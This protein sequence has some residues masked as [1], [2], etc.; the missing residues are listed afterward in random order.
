[1]EETTNTPETLLSLREKKDGGITLKF[2]VMTG[3]SLWNSYPQIE[4]WIQWGD[5]LSYDGA[6]IGDHYMHDK[7][8]HMQFPEPNR[9]FDTWIALSYLAAKTGQIRLGTFV[10]PL[11]L[12]DPRILA[13]QIATLDNLSGGRVILG[14]GAGW[15]ESE[16]RAYS[17]WG[18]PKNRVDRVYEALDLMI[19]LWTEELVDY[20]GKFF[21]CKGAILDPKP[22][23]KPYPELLFGSTGKRMIALSAKYGNVISVGG[24]AKMAMPEIMSKVN[25]SVEK[26]GR[27]GAVHLM[28]GLPGAMGPYDPKSHIDMIEEALAKGCTYYMMGFP[29]DETFFASM[30]HF[31]EEIMP[32]YR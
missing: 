15:S 25:T 6:L 9:T 26:A 22:I 1:L 29:M 24:M 19:K 23:Q 17:R 7:Q 28:E 14:I 31:A 5:E 16:H 12:R 21:K 10:T 2:Y 3:T 13:K 8:G 4:Q 11:T 30:K 32:S 18:S 27:K 20:E